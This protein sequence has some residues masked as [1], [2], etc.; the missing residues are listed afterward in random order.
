MTVFAPIASS[1][2]CS[3]EGNGIGLTM[4]RKLTVEEIAAIKAMQKRGGSSANQFTQEVLA[5]VKA[6]AVAEAFAI[7]VPQGTEAQHFRANVKATLDRY[8][9][10]AAQVK[11]SIDVRTNEVMIQKIA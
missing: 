6:L 7:A 10:K 3:L 9:F 11:T 1:T 2:H 5:Q 4:F 8:G